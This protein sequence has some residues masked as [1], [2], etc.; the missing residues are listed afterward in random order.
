MGDNV[1]ALLTAYLD[2]EA[3]D[4]SVRVRLASYV[5]QVL[6]QTGFTGG[7]QQDA[8]ECL[9]HLL[10][11][12]DQGRMQGRVC[13]ANAVASVESMILCEIADEAQVAR[14][15]A[16]VSSNGLL[17]SSL[18][19][20]QAIAES[21]PA[22]VVRVENMYEHAG[23]YFTVDAR[24]DWAGFPIELTVRNAPNRG[25]QYVVAGYV[26]H[27]SDPAVSAQRRMRSGHYVAYIHLEGKWFEL[28]DAHVTEL[29]V[30]PRRFS[31][32]GVP[33]P[34]RHAEATAGQ[35]SACHDRCQND[36]AATFAGS[37]LLRQINRRTTSDETCTAA[38]TIWAG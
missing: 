34:Q 9:M 37:I 20:D 7:V 6:R 36:R 21:V 5:E 17:M 38:R 32:S 24:A 26:A 16:P 23:D 18:T 30:P 35:A 31:I 10:L 22:L 29:A 25:P 14:D 19:G 11:S 4:A 8:A 28:D 2:A 1:R 27:V 33:E 15:A 12:I 13:G 3:T